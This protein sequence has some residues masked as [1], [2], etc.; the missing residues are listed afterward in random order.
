MSW[1]QTNREV[2]VFQFFGKK[3]KPLLG[4][5]ISSTSVK[6]LQ[7]TSSD[8][9]HRVEAFGVE[10]MPESAVVDKEIK[11]LEAVSAA[12]KRLVARAKPSTDVAALAVSGGAVMTR[13]VQMSHTLS[14]EEIESQIE[15]EAE[16]SIPYPLDEV[17]LDFDVLGPNERDPKM[18]DVLLAA[19]R[20]EKVDMLVD[21]V[22]MAG[23]RAGVVDVEAYALARAYG[24][25]EHEKRDG[26]VAV[27]DIGASAMTL[28]VLV[29]GNIIY[30]RDQAFGGRQLT[31]EVQRRYGLSFS[32]AGLAKKTGDLP[33]DFEPEVLG[34]FKK[35]VSQQITRSLQF[36][37]SST[38]NTS[39]DAIVLA[40]GTCR[41]AGLTSLIAE[42]LQRPVT[43]A[44]PFSKMLVSSRVD[45]EAL[46]KD[47]P[48]LMICCGLALRSL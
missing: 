16:R 18:L 48:A 12:I 2:Q 45:R 6:L 27:V 7:L 38:D 39:V 17:S 13:V 30:S 29:E 26:V 41:I 15:V 35:A 28:N 42:D 4:L 11:D 3:K 21:A 40:G 9:Q 19:S 47:A 5:D 22:E 20:T 31:E 43:L 32:E 10:P 1:I 44:N 36:F 33:D 14:A 34:P 24:L 46:E 37:F 25:L 23:L 8:K